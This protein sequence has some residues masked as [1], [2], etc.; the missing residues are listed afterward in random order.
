MAKKVL[1]ISP[2]ATM[3]G[4]ETFVLNACEGHL[5]HGTWEVKLLFLNRGPLY[6]KARD[7]NINSVLLP[8]K[9]RFFNFISLIRAIFFVRAI[10]KEENFDVIHGTMPYAHIIN[11]FA[12]IGLDVKTVWFQHGPVGGKF[13]FICKFLDSDRVLF[14]SRFL[15]SQHYQTFRKDNISNSTIIPLAVREPKGSEL[16]GEFSPLIDQFVITCAGRISGIKG[17]DLAINAM[18]ELKKSRSLDG[19]SL[20][21]IGEAVRDNEKAYL[22]SLKDLVAKNDLSKYVRFIG[23]QE[24]L[25][26]FFELTD[27]FVLPTTIAEAFGLVAAEAML[28][29]TL[30]IGSNYGGIEETLT[31]DTGIIFDS[32]QADS[33]GQL[34][35]A[36]ASVLEQTFDQNKKVKD[37]YNEKI[38]QAY[39]HVSQNY[40]LRKMIK[41]LED[42]YTSLTYG[43]NN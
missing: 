41:N 31:D 3:G 12:T 6:D 22:K 13:D 24:S 28:K 18:A 10:I 39:N 35:N 17:Y 42:I 4:A 37:V 9:L 20:L 36:L 30:V 43:Q 14:N 23:P 38:I 16:S 26:P 29:N 25:S 21:I 32:R 27:I 1:Y 7:L 15:Q 11:F 40:S 33:S 19:I 8:F 2:N 34:K 5:S